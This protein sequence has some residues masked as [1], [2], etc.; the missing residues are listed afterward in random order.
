MPEKLR[1]RVLMEGLTGAYPRAIYRSVG[2]T[3]EDL[4]KPQIAVVNSWSETN[5]GHVHLRKLA[6]CVKE[7]VWAAGGM[8]VEFNVIAP[9]DGVAQGAGMHYILPSRDIIAASIELMVQ[10]HMFD[11]MVMLASCDKIIP[12]M[13]MAA[14]TLDLPT[15][16]VPGGPMLARE[17]AGGKMVMSD[18]KEAMGRLQAGKI[19]AEEFYDIEANTNRTCGACGMMGTAN[20]MSC[21]VEALGL[22][23]P[24]AGTI[25][26]VEARRLRLAR[27]SGMQAVEL[28]RQGLTARQMINRRG[29]TNAIRVT[30]AMGGS[31]NTVLHLPAIARQAGWE[32]P[33]SL[34]DELSRTTPLLAKFKPASP[35]TLE[36]FDAA[37]GVM[38]LMKE[39]APLLDLDLP[40][41]SGTTLR[42]QVAQAQ[43]KRRDVIHPL[44]QP[45][46]TEG[47]LAVLYGNLA[48]GGAVVKQSGV[49]PRMLVHRGPA[50]V[51]NSE[52]EVKALLLGGRVKPGDVLVIKY[53]GPKGGPGMREMSI[54]AALLVGMGLDD[55]VAMITDGRYSGATRGPCIGYVTPEAIEGGPLAVVEDG[56]MIVIDIPQRR[57]EVELSAEEIRNRLKVWSP[58]PAKIKRGFMSRYPALVRSVQEGACLWNSPPAE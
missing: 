11:G 31:S 35:F 44:D 54:P 22:S 5:P 52:E 47:G 50:R 49:S 9:C 30:M 28:V 53:E 37:G 40:T 17:Y 56:D 2:F 58:P 41:V 55:S 7:G 3:D 12:G 24:G 19:T 8:P 18:I 14:A 16:F 32:M 38:A 57:L 29:L 26:A 1:S 4:Q 46:A 13:L 6:R 33:L 27:K 20:T 15:V 23:L 25:P 45:L 48:P 21:L 10:A 51:A 34:F 39:L 36:D 42:A 43:V